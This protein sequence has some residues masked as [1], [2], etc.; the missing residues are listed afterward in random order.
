MTPRTERGDDNR[1]LAVEY[2]NAEIVQHEF[3]Q[4]CVSGAEYIVL[5]CTAWLL[6]TVTQM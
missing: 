4:K 6:S 2:A 3:A 1:A 5:R